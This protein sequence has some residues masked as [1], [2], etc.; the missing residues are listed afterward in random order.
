MKKSR[1][2]ISKSP[3]SRIS[4]PVKKI[5]TL[6]KSLSLDQI[7]VKFIDPTIFL[8]FER[9]KQYSYKFYNG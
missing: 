8:K 7:E 3:Y 4:K 1:D 2:Y 6:K 5:E 9:S